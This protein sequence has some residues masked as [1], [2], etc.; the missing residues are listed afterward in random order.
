MNKK[1]EINTYSL[2]L[3]LLLI[4][5]GGFSI[6]LKDKEVEKKEILPKIEEFTHLPNFND[7][8]S[9]NAKVNSFVDFI[10]PIIVFEN[11]KILNDRKY[12][13]NLIKKQTFNS[14]DSLW[15]QE[16]TAYYKIKSTK[17]NKQVLAELLNRIDIVPIEIVLAQAAIESNWGTSA[18][19]TKYNNLFGTRTSSKKNGIVPKKRAKTETYRVAAYRTVN[20]SIRSYLRNINSHRAYADFRNI[21]SQLRSQNKPLDSFLLAEHLTAYSTLGTKYVKIIKNIIRNHQNT[22]NKNINKEIS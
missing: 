11:Q 6:K 14:S 1:L 4:I 16:K 2:S 19:A 15:L 20:Q 22:F 12:L 13:Q 18:F 21:R 9:T 8:E 3:I 10:T 7:C 17:Y 5:F